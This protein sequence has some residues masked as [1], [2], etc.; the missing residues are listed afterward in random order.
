MLPQ[1]SEFLDSSVTPER[2]TI[3]LRVMSALNEIG[4]ETH[5]DELTSYL[6]MNDTVDADNIVDSIEIILRKAIETALSEYGIELIEDFNI[7]IGA[8]IITATSNLD[9]YVDSTT[10]LTLLSNLDSPESLFADVLDLT[11][12][13]NAIEYLGNIE[14]VSPALIERLELLHAKAD[15]YEVQET[16]D[17]HALSRLKAHM[18]SEIEKT[19]LKSWV[20][21]G[22]PIGLTIDTYVSKFDSVE[23]E[24]TP[25]ELATNALAI[26][27]ASSLPDDQLDSYAVRFIEEREHDI[28]NALVAIAHYRKTK[29]MVDHA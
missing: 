26:V 1:L 8:D 25:V 17:T 9:N 22:L 12:G 16:T 27:L 13:F 21:E 4:F 29:A 18:D 19:R 2:K 6:S 24:F 11:G 15:S 23:G 14:K 10:I 20:D 5:N 3:F 28:N 7:E